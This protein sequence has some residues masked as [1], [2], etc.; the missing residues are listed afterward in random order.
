[1]IYLKRKYV[2]KTRFRYVTVH[3]IVTNWLQKKHRSL[4]FKYNIFCTMQNI[5]STYT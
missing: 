2:F 1:M 4:I 5:K 3:N